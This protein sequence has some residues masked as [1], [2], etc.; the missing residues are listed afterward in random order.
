MKQR[1]LVLYNL[2]QKCEIK[3]SAFEEKMQNAKRK[4]QN[5]FGRSQ[6]FLIL[7]LV[8]SSIRCDL[9]STRDPDPPAQNNSTFIQPVSADIVLENLK[10]SVTESNT[11]NYFRCFSDV[12]SGRAYFFLPSVEI[13]AQYS[14]VFSS[15]TPEQERMY[16]QN[17]GQPSN[18]T[19]YLTFS[20]SSTLAVSS[21][22]VV[23][24]MDYTFFYP[25]RR[26][27]ITQLVQGNMQIFL[28]A[29]TQRLW[30]IY[31]WHDNKTVSDSTWSYWKAVFSGS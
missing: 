12:A 10:K 2:E 14:S 7:L 15:W 25:H 23:Y 11:D 20:N 27:G 3:Q 5:I 4:T 19:A 31:R 17:L 29:N 6:S 26:S 9:F 22:S 13:S 28:G 1:L 16:F 30:S 18:G 8:I 24:S 21:D